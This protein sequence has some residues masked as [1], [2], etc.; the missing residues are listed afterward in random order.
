MEALC[1]FTKKIPKEED[2]LYL[3]PSIYSC[4]TKKLRKNLFH[5]S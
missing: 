4:T 2:E 5:P 1:L 3:L